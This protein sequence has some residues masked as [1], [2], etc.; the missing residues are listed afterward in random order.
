MRRVCIAYQLSKMKDLQLSP[1]ALDVFSVLWKRGPSTL[2]EVHAE[3]QDRHEYTTVQTMLDRL[4]EKGLVRRDR[5]VRPARHRAILSRQRALQ[6]FMRSVV[7]RI[8]DG[9]APVVLQLLQ[10]STFSKEELAEIRRLIDAAE[11]AAERRE[12]GDNS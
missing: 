3:L 11:V 5:S 4:V 6:Y 8:C 7:N 10:E 12:T 9:P 2:G 1:A